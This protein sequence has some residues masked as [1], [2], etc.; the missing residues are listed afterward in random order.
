[1]LV[2]IKESHGERGGARLGGEGLSIR[3]RWT[4]Y[5]ASI[6]TCFLKYKFKS[7]VSPQSVL[8]TTAFESRDL[9]SSHSSLYSEHPILIHH[10]CVKPYRDTMKILHSRPLRPT[11]ASTLPTNPFLASHH[12]LNRRWRCH[13]EF[14]HQSSVPIQIAKKSIIHMCYSALVAS[15]ISLKFQ[16]RARKLSAYFP[17]STLSQNMANPASC[18]R[19]AY[20]DSGLDRSIFC[21]TAQT[22]LNLQN[23]PAR[24]TPNYPSPILHR[25][26]LFP[27]RPSL[28]PPKLTSPPH[29]P[30]LP[31]PSRRHPAHSRIRTRTRSHHG[32]TN[33]NSLARF[34]PSN[35]TSF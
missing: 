13:T 27:P 32:T 16:F 1:M 12:N 30:T 4:S 2:L 19:P 11:S 3:L 15:I 18:K 5:P 28:L 31:F 9:L 24:T 35:A 7:T 33:H 26:S 34:K 20:Q 22:L 8:S 6:C 25:Y 10:I 21:V 29:T 14:A 23:P 17:P